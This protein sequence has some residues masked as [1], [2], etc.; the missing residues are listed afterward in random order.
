MSREPGWSPSIVILVVL[1]FVGI[2]L[3]VA[4]RQEPPQPAVDLRYFHLHPDAT[5]QMLDVSDASMQVKRV[6]AYRHVPMWDVRHLMEEYVVTRGGRGR[7]RQMVD[8]PRLNQAL[9]ERWPM[10]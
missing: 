2:I 7:G 6:S 5:D 10:K 1:S 9:D 8:I 3:A 4:G